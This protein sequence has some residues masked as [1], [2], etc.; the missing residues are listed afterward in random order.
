MSRNNYRI[1]HFFLGNIII[2]E[3]RGQVILPEG[4]KY[5]SFI[6]YISQYLYMKVQQ[7]VFA[8]IR[9]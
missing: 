5:F 4:W 8:E 7:P 1:K 9:H 3:A 6:F 2:Y